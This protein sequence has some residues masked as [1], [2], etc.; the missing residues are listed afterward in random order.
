MR[1]NGAFGSQNV[2]GGTGTM[3]EQSVQPVDDRKAMDE[4]YEKYAHKKSLMIL[5]QQVQAYFGYVPE[6]AINYLSERMHVSESHIYGVIT[7]YAQFRTK[8]VGK[9]LVKVC[10]GTACHVGGASILSESLNSYLGLS[11]ISDTT[12]DGIFTIQDVACLGCCALAPAMMV[13]NRVHGKLDVNSIK[14][15][16]DSYRD[17]AK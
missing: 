7:F 9:Y 6:F 13:N 14:K 1:R 2:Q 15:I 4:I 12:A 8:P 16:I 5:L 3:T 17:A 10:H 11:E